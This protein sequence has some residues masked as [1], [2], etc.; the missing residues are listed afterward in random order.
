MQ[1][2]MTAGTTWTTWTTD[3]TL[4]THTHNHIY[5]H[6]HTHNH[7][8]RT[9]CRRLRLDS[10]HL[11]MDPQSQSSLRNLTAYFIYI[12][13]VA[14]LGPLLFGFHLVCHFHFLVYT[15]DHDVI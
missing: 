10:T 3:P 4:P 9:C 12:L 1:Q 15:D 5:N 6:T 8:P 13:F 14:T 2:L 7:N 11:A